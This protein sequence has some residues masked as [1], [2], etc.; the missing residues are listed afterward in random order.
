MRVLTVES[1]VVLQEAVSRFD[2]L[3]YGI[4]F[5]VSTGVRFG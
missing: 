5:A 3:R 4:T 2:E 1:Q